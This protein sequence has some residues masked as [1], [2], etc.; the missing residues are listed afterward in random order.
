MHYCWF[1][2][3]MPRATKERI[4]S[5]SRVCPGFEVIGW[6]EQSVPCSGSTYFEQALKCGKWAFASDVARIAV[7]REFGGVYLDTDV[8]VRK[9]LNDLLTYDSFL[10]YESNRN[11]AT[12]VIGS[13]GDNWL[14][15][16]MAEYYNHTELIDSRGYIDQTTN[17]Q[18]LT[19]I[20]VEHGLVPNGHGATVENVAIL[21]M[22]YLVAK[23][24][25]TERLFV[26]KDTYTI[27]LFESSWMSD[28]RLRYERLVKTLK[29]T[30]GNRWVAS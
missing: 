18:V 20:L 8:E 9:P 4:E 29:K 12:C 15:Q 11:V 1:G 28:E 24:Y 30:L 19:R 5:W 25:S 27:H 7:L 26:T 17:V 3:V 10:G 2:G 6:N 21:P 16:S 13:T 22:K 23:D 14:L